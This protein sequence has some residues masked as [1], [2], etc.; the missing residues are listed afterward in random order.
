MD[1]YWGQPVI[2]MDLLVVEL[3]SYI[4]LFYDPLDCSLL[5]FSVLGKNTGVGCYIL[6]QGIFPNLRLNVHLQHGKWILYHCITS[7]AHK[8]GMLLLLLLSCFSRVR[9]CATPW[10]AAHQAS[11][12][13]G[14]SRQ[15]HWSGLPFPSPMHE[16]CMKNGYRLP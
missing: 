6:L 3:L 9:L 10:T 11:P 2:K 12:S 16:K 15:E 13:M 8:M 4:Q 7:E 1:S 5:G 14:F